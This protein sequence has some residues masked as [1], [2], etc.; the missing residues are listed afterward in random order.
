[1]GNIRVLQ[2]GVGRWGKN[3]LRNLLELGVDLYLCD[4]NDAVFGLGK[5]AGLPAEKISSNYKDLFN[6]V[7]AVDI[8]T[9]AD[10]HYSLCMEFIEGGKDVFVEKPIT[11]RSSEA[12]ELAERAKKLNR[13]IQVGHI[14]R[15]DPATQ[16]MKSEIEKGTIGRPRWME[17]RFLG[18]KRPRPDSGISFADSLHFIDLF[19]YLLDAVPDSVSASFA[20]ILGRGMEDSSCIALDYGGA[21][22]S[23]Q[24]NYFMPGKERMVAVVGEE[25]S[26]MCDYDAKENGVRLFR[27]R[28][29]REGSIWKAEEGEVVIP[30]LPKGENLKSELADFLECVK[31]RRNPRADACDGYKVVKILEAACR[32]AR[33]GKKII[34]EKE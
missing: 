1:M 13:I 28:H 10:N 26:I 25:A 30:D 6:S 18:F 21:F 24:A 11:L 27:N 2:I 8:V 14:F 9:P 22:A 5:D 20:D 32:S 19:N 17:A 29:Y 12:F 33:Q 3:H 7:D 4:I 16:W 23:V 34:M 31:K 15:F